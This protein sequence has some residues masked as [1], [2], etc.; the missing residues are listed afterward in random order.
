VAG[1][2]TPPPPLT[3]VPT[4]AAAAAASPLTHQCSRVIANGWLK[5]LGTAT[6]CFMAAAL[7]SESG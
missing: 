7:I 2:L 3:S 4:P 6:V 5:V 1:H